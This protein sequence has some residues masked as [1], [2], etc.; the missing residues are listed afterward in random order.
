MHFFQSCVLKFSQNRVHFSQYLTVQ[1]Q[2][3]GYVGV[4]AVGIIQHVDIKMFEEIATYVH[5][6]NILTKL[7]NYNLFAHLKCNFATV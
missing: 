1:L 3:A 7:T 5:N 2:F 6:L 4:I